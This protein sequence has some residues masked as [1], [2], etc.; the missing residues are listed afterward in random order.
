MQSGSVV[1]STA[2]P[3]ETFFTRMF[4]PWTHFVPIANDF[5]DLAEKLD[6][7]RAHDDECRD[8]ARRARQHAES[9]YRPEYVGRVVARQWRSL[10]NEGSLLRRTTLAG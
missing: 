10:L 8:M 7:C 2:S 9:V 5:A 6:W 1:L 4:E 3:W